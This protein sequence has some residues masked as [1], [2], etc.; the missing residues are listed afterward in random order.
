[1]TTLLDMLHAEQARMNRVRDVYDE[2]RRRCRL[3]SQALSDYEQA[4]SERRAQLRLPAK[5]RDAYLLAGWAHEVTQTR[6]EAR[7]AIAA[8]RAARAAVDEAIRAAGLADPGLGG[9]P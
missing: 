7:R 8:F 9:A 4:K 5:R 1:M 2:E 6:H 3:L